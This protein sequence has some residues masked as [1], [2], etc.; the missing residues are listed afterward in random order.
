MSRPV[1]AM[2]ALADALETFA[3]SL[4]RDVQSPIS[5]FAGKPTSSH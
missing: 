3:H 5:D 2:A 1:R 4:E